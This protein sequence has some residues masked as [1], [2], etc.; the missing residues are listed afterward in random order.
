[1]RREFIETSFF[2]RQWC[3]LALTDEDMEVLQ[4]AIMKNPHAAPVIP[5][6][7][8][9]RKLRMPLPGRGKRGGARILY[10]DLVMTERVYL[11]SAYA[12]NELANI[13]ASTKVALNRLV[14]EIRQMEARN[15]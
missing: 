4:H 7:E 9:I 10:I 15:D 2:T 14:R 11:L 8:G 1:M 5:G 3:D 6:T 13:S 12:K